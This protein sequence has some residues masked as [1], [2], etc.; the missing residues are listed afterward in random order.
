MT[1]RARLLLDALVKLG[2][3][4]GDKN[5]YFQAHIVFRIAPNRNDL[6]KN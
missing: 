5:A 3:Y 6:M 4:N 1:V 2:S